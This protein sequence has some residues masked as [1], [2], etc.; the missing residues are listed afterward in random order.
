MKTHDEDAKAWDSGQL[1]Q[2]E[3][4]VAALASVAGTR[5]GN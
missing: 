2:D 3:A 5:R 4:H 1:G